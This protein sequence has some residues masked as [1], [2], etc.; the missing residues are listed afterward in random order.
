MKVS[1][2]V[3]SRCLYF[4]TNALARKTE[5]L[6][7]ESWAKVDLPPSHAYLLMLVLEQPGIQPGA[8]S[9]QLQL[10]PS[11]ISRLIEKLED[12]QLLFRTTEGKTVN[13]YPTTRAKTLLPRLK[14]CQDE[15][16]RRYTAALGESESEL[17]V[18]RLLKVADKI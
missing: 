6:A 8:I 5:K 1:E 4:S 9:E 11:T 2:S 7:Q 15:F 10:T 16:C 14:A 13:V 17:F 3:F 12:K 18:N